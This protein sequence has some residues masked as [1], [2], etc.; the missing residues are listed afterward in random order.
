MA[1]KRMYSTHFLIRTED[2]KHYYRSC[3]SS[4]IWACQEKQTFSVITVNCGRCKQTN[5]YKEAVRKIAA[6]TRLLS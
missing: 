1:S 4:C 5:A 3:D 2:C 6:N